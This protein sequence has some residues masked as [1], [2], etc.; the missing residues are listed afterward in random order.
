M[1]KDI[2]EIEAA[3]AAEFRNWLEENHDKADAVWLVFW[4]KDSGRPSIAWTEAVDQALSFGWIDSKVQSIDGDRYRQYFTVRK[5]GS[6]W[7]RINK[8]KI[9]TLEAAGLL[10]PAGRAAVDRAKEDGSWSILDGPE[11]GIVPE[12]LAAALDAGGVRDVFDDLTNGNRK[13]ILTWLVMAKRDATRANRIAKTVDA[14]SRGEL[15]M[16]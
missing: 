8:E 3:D 5:P 9:A 12:D 10:A 2:A 14:L 15:P 6:V 16:G 13:A 11:A 7:S 1:S 4:K